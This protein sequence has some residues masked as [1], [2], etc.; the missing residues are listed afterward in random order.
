MQF[1]HCHRQSGIDS[2]QH[3]WKRLAQVA[4][5]KLQAR[6]SVECSAEDEAEGM[7]RGFDV[8]SPAAFA[9]QS[10]TSAV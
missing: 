3:E 8:P 4:D 1:R 6:V 10:V 7:D 9:S 2:G 5:D